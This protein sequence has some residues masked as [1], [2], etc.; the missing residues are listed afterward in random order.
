MGVLCL[1]Q[2]EFSRFG[3]GRTDLRQWRRDGLRPWCPKTPPSS[4][5]RQRCLTTIPPA[6]APAS[7]AGDVTTPQGYHS[8]DMPKHRTGRDTSAHDCLGGSRLKSELAEL[9]SPGPSL[10]KTR[11][12]WIFGPCFSVKRIRGGRISNPRG[13]RCSRKRAGFET[14]PNCR[15]LAASW[16]WEADMCTSPRHVPAR[17][18]KWGV[19]ST[20]SRGVPRQGTRDL[21][22][23]SNIRSR[24]RL[25][26][27]LNA[28]DVGP[29][30][31]TTG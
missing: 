17:T 20:S 9:R 26:I 1:R 16:S 27:I 22:S 3:R 24:V 11:K 4:N 18:P 7:R 31:K 29:I 10:G 14:K 2:G 12:P 8:R 15:T 19:Q 25:G 28:V 6:D 21:P 5:F 30:Q 23:F 13:A